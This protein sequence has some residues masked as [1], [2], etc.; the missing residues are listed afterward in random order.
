M[1]VYA[2]EDAVHREGEGEGANHKEREG[3]GKQVGEDG[4]QV[5][6]DQKRAG[7]AI[8]AGTCV[9]A[10]NEGGGGGGGEGMFAQ[11]LSGK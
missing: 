9:G 1:Y 2:G 3:E 4:E 10:L 5:G 8:V 11:V 7:E 6:G